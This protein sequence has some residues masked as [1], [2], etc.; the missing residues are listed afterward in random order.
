MKHQAFLPRILVALGI[1]LSPLCLSPAL[2]IDDAKAE[3]AGIRKLPGKR[4]TL[5][6]D[7]TGKEIDALPD[8]FEQAFPQWCKYFHVSERDLP[9][10][11]MTGFLMK[12]KDRFVAA[13]LL[14]KDLPPF[15]HGFSKGDT[16]W[17]YDQ[18]S[19][20]YRRHLL[21]HEGVHGFMNTVLGR[22]G[23]PWYMEGIAEFLGTHRLQ[24][25]RLTLGYMPQNRAETP[26]WGRIRIIQDAVAAGKTLPLPQVIDFPADRRSETEYYAW[27]WALATLLDRHPRYQE[28]FR[29]LVEHV[30][31]ADFNKRFFQSFSADWQ[32]LCEEW[33]LMMA[34]LEY[35]DDVPRSA[36]DFSPAK[37]SLR[38][39]GEESVRAV[40]IA[41]DRG[42]Q[43]TGLHLEAGVAYHL[44]ASGR[45][46]VAI[47]SPLP[48]GEGQGVRA[49]ETSHHPK[50]WWSEPGGVSI[51]YYQGRP[52]GILLAAV[53]PDQPPQGSVSAL[54]H[55]TVIGLGATLTP[56]ESGTLFLK[57][58]DSSGELSDNAGT[59]N[60]ELRQQ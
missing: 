50:I 1:S 21:L 25:G 47:G 49:V 17:I 6:T 13:E 29:E 5:Y 58:N 59:L 20:Y 46:Q 48:L 2:A 3:A 9:D 31:E 8:I 18:P 41:A 44:T 57:I 52:L 51:R 28:R 53:R 12:D 27:C 10:W 11:H 22:C 43:N 34:N 33:Q 14:P 45:Y 24:D 39:L 38:P 23:P 30:R 42:W 60:V 35:G 26:E 32:A 55:P 54:L 40:T 36:V 37:L 16:L 19:D 15:A 7:L 56:T 4:L